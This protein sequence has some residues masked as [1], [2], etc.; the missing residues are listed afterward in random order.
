MARRSKASKAKG[1]KKSQGAAAGGRGE[2]SPLSSSATAEDAASSGGADHGGGASRRRRGREGGGRDDQGAAGTRPRGE[3]PFGGKRRREMRASKLAEEEAL[4]G[5]L[6]GGGGGGSGGAA[7]ALGAGATGAWA[8]EDDDDLLGGGDP[9]GGE[10]GYDGEGGGDAP[11]FA[12]DREGED[13]DDGGDG[14]EGGRDEAR[15]NYDRAEDD[16]SGGGSS[17][18]D[19][20]ED[21]EDAAR[22]NVSMKGAAWRD[23]DADDSSSVPSSSSDESDSDNEGQIHSDKRPRSNEKE[24]KKK[25]GMVSLV[26]GPN[27]LKKLRRRAD[28]TDPLS[29]GEYELRLR[30]RHASTAGAAART[31]WADVSRAERRDGRTK[32]EAGS[33]KKK[34]KRYGSDDE[35]DDDEEE[36]E[37]DAARRIL[38]SSAPLLR[39][40][41]RGRPLPPTLLD[42]V[43][44][45][46]ANLSDPNRSAVSSCAFHPGSD[47]ENPLLMTAGMDKTL[48]FFRVDG[49]SEKG[50]CDKVHGMHFP[51]MPISCASFLGD[52]GSVVLSGRRPFFYVYDAVSG[53]VERVTSSMLGRDERSLERFATSPD[54]RLIAFVGND[55][56]VILV[57]G[58][59]RRWV[60]DLKM[61]GS[62]RAV[63]FSGDGEHVLGSGSDGD[64]YRWHVGSRRCVERFHNE[65][66][67]VTSS[68]ALSSDVLAVGAES[69]VV[70]LYDGPRGPSSAGVGRLA[71]ATSHRTPLKSVLNLTTSADALRFNHDGKILAMSTRRE[72]D[73][74]K[75]LHVPTATVFSNWPTSKTPLKY[76]WSMDF[77][78]GSRYLAVGNDGGKCLLYR[79]RHYWDE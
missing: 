8:D 44:V 49:S 53:A 66:G 78:P 39:P 59:T 45:R 24:E 2:P 4:T 32:G 68:L 14:E 23:S 58:K 50:G 15:K 21:E 37:D 65:D 79:L 38:E 77:S 30:E 54:G 35:G 73:G 61:N 62:V 40:S 19:S 47:R 75:L 9:S 72:V 7:D 52:S 31:D 56:Y 5:L 28:E 27:R 18:E 13:V 67:T 42:V 33:A 29:L 55:G 57:D 60:G 71:A 43:R 64:V 22:K 10:D 25:K 48:R 12:I 63:T 20:T 1:A 41:G 36:E 76:V 3:E 26:D 74:L 69:G 17:Y 16:E 34:A 11:L 6:F 46:D 70:N 51:K